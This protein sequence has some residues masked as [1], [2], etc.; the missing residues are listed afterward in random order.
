[1]C[2]VEEGKHE[3]K[4]L[5]LHDYD[6]VED[7]IEEALE[8]FCGIKK[9]YSDDVIVSNDEFVCGSIAIVKKGKDDNHLAH[10]FSDN[11]WHEAE[12]TD[13]YQYAEYYKVSELENILPKLCMKNYI[14]NSHFDAYNI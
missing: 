2:K 10:K 9:Y 6:C 1:M 7:I 13:S 3:M 14:R 8:T 5:K 11:T 4:D 12:I